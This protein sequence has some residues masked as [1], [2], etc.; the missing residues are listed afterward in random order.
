MVNELTSI[1][2]VQFLTIKHIL[3]KINYIFSQAYFSAR[4]SSARAD[5]GSPYSTI[6]RFFARAA[7]SEGCKEEIST[8]IIIGLG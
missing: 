5:V 8:I 3:T 6:V 4:R 2:Y 1:K 7:T